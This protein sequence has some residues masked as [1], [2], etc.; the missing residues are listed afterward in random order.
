MAKLEPEVPVVVL[1]FFA[2][3]DLVENLRKLG[4]IL[5]R[6]KEAEEFIAFY[7]EIE[8]QIKGRVAGLSEEE[9]PRVF[10]KAS[11]WTPE[12]LCTFTD[13]ANMAR[14]QIAL[15]GGIN[16][17]ADLPGLWVGDVDPEWLIT[18][19]PHNVIVPMNPGFFPGSFGYEIDDKTVAKA[20]REQI[21]NMDVFAGSDAVKEERV[22]LYDSELMMTPR[23]VAG[24]AYLAK[25]F[26][27]E[28]FS[29]LDPQAI[30]QEYLTRFMRIDFD[31]SK[32]GVF[33]Y[34]EP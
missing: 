6:E 28:L 24:M 1:N 22:Y 21:M 11:G 29:D 13:K 23:L 4:S 19:N 2:P 33:V 27:P 3:E 12:Q 20:T 9:K 34:P 15:P 31:L 14:D 8:N 30:H 25:W 26:H 17:A 18:Q 16:I 7:Q 10:L 5:D 32:H